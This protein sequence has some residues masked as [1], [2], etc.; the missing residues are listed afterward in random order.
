MY[1]YG[2]L[3]GVKHGVSTL[4]QCALKI[5][6]TVVSRPTLTRGVLDSGSKVLSSDTMGLDGYGMI[7]EYPDA[8]IYQ[9]SEEHGHV[10]FSS[11]QR[12]SAIGERVTIIPNHVCVVS[13]LFNEIVGIRG[14]RV[15][16]VWPVAARGMLR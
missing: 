6:A 8:V 2:D 16:V 7:V 5:L 15:E 9:L 11:Q 3:Y 12:A 13:N 10:E 1:V 4:A 14:D